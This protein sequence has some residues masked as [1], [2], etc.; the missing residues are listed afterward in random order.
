MMELK[1]PSAGESITEVQIGEWYHA[2]GDVVAADQPVVVIETEKA[3]LE[4][5]APAAGKLVR[6][7]K[8]TGEVAKPG[9]VIGE[10]EPSD[11]PV[12]SAPP[13]PAREQP[14]SPKPAPVPPSVP[15]PAV[16]AP[17][18]ADEVVRMSPLR[19]ALA[20]RLVEAR[21]A[22]AL[23]T[24]FNEVDMSAVMT[25]RREWGELFQQK[26]GVKLG[27][28]SFFVK[29][30]IEALKFVPQVNS[31]V[32]GG[33]SPRIKRLS[34]YIGQS[35]FD[36]LA[37]LDDLTLIMDES[38]RYRASAGVRAINELKPVLGLELTSAAVFFYFHGNISCGIH[39]FFQ[40]P[41]A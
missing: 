20:R 25:L 40:V 16:P 10:V 8:R 28:M 15:T 19:R 36:Y 21:Q 5:T 9:E 37:E 2:E 13:K 6:I 22:A 17:A 39:V 33:K 14:P 35:Y 12:S 30:A 24:T 32:R 4:V 11:Q 29:A 27:L 34:E 18:A 3:T 26:H 31:E 41:L 1:V 38:H 23:L 7:L